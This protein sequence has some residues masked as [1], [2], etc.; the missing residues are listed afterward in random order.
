MLLRVAPYSA[1]LCRAGD[2]SPGCPE[3]SVHFAVPAM[4]HRVAPILASSALPVVKFQVA[5]IPH[6]LAAP[7]NRF[8]V[9]PPPA[10][11]LY[12]RW[13]PELPRVPHPSAVPIDQ[14][15]GLPRACQS[16]GI[17]DDQFPGCPESCIFRHRLMDLR[18]TSVRAPSGC[19]F[20][21][22]PGCPGSPSLASASGPLSGLP[23][24]LGPSATPID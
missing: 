18:V 12:R 19:A 3:S 2:E 11:R 1:R 7:P 17:A 15:T 4:D 23:Q 9:A 5:L 6:S 21:E 16:F 13:I 22:S 8:R 20:V 24:I 10:L 14:F